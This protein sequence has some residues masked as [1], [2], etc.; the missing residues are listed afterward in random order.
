M[1][2]IS[3]LSAITNPYQPFNQS[4]FGQFGQDFQAIGSALQSG[5]LTQAQTAL[6]T[7][8]QELQGN[9]QSSSS[10]S[11]SSQPFGSNSQANSDY[12]TLVSSL[13]SGNLSNAQKAFSSLQTDLKTSHKG[14][15][16]HHESSSTSSSTA[17]TSNSTTN[18]AISTLLDADGGNILDLTA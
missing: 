1:S 3:S 2:S 9:S 5:N 13:Q 17:S 10:S 14:G 4:G 8:Q 7:F 11:S 15:H 16:H 6:A 18:N 12:Q